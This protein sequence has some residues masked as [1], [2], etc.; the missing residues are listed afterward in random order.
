MQTI[1]QMSDREIAQ[2][3]GQEATDAEGAAMRAA[4]IRV[5]FGD[6]AVRDVP[7]LEWDRILRESGADCA[8]TVDFTGRLCLAKL[9]DGE[10]RLIIFA[11]RAQAQ[12]RVNVLGRGWEVHQSLLSRRFI[13]R[14]A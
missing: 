5:G 10:P 1:N 2:Y 6:V 13:V 9:V 4:L 3:M 8:P 7:D 14:R 12:R 11:N